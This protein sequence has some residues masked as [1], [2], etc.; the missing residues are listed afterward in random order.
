MKGFAIAGPDKAFH[1]AKAKIDGDSVLVWNETIPNPAFIRYAWANNPE[2][3]LYNIPVPL[4]KRTSLSVA[5]L[6]PALFLS[7]V[8]TWSW[9]IYRRSTLR[10]VFPGASN[11]YRLTGNVVRTVTRLNDMWAEPPRLVAFQLPGLHL[12]AV[13]AIIC[14]RPTARGARGFLLSPGRNRRAGGEQ[15]R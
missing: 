13:L 1:W 2:C 11:S 5:I 3:T 7:R 6:C 10:P 9:D 15:A 4:A 14:F 8:K 12:L